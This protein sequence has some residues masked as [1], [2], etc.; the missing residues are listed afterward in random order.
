MDTRLA[1]GI[2]FEHTNTRNGKTLRR[3]VRAAYL[4][5]ALGDVSALEDPSAADAIRA[6][7]NRAALA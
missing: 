2:G 7:C 1:S 3:L 5:A 4:G 6:C